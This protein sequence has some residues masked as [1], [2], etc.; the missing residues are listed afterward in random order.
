MEEEYKRQVEFFK[1]EE[2]N[3]KEKLREKELFY[4][5][6]QQELES[7]LEEQMRLVSEFT[8]IYLLSVEF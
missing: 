5:Q 4:L 3:T 1:N 7:R 8:V 6:N 2:K